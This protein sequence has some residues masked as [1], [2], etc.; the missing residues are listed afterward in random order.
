[1]LLVIY[2]TASAIWCA[3]FYLGIQKPDEMDGL[4]IAIFL[5][6]VIF[7]GVMLFLGAKTNRL[8]READFWNEQIVERRAK[9]AEE[10]NKKLQ[11]AEYL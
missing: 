8:K 11:D 9:I 3:F 6:T 2:A 10:E 4:N 1:M 5:A 7:W